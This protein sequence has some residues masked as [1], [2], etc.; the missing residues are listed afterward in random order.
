VPRLVDATFVLNRESVIPSGLNLIRLGAA[1]VCL[2]VVVGC[3][4][5]SADQQAGGQSGGATESAVPGCSG[6]TFQID[7]SAGVPSAATPLRA[8]ADFEHNGTVA[9]E[10]PVQYGF[11]AGG[12]RKV[13][14]GSTIATY[15]SGR[16]T[17]HLAKLGSGN[18]QVR[19]GETCNG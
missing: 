2:L 16:S 19:S 7:P 5:G 8:I 1:A 11:P 10:D 6:R 15:A 17:L 13:H 18:W 4:S 9:G 12:W 14:L 3:R